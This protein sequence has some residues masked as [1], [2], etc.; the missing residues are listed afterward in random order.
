M[1]DESF[2]LGG[3]IL[4]K[5][6][7]RAKILAALPPAFLTAVLQDLKAAAV[8]LTF[9]LILTALSRPPARK[10]AGRILTVN[11]F[12]AFLWIVLPFST[13][14]ERLASFGPLSVTYEGLQLALLVTLKSNALFLLFLG[15]VATT[16]A[17]DLGRSLGML[18][19]PD[20]LCQLLIFSY[21]YV[22]VLAQ[23]Y[24]RL[25]VAIRVRGFKPGMNLHTYRTAAYLAAMLL[26]RGYDRA[27]RVRQAMVLRGFDGRF[28]SLAEYSLRAPDYYLLTASALALGLVAAV[29]WA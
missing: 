29:E 28:H 10:L 26:V 9:A 22:H 21:R 1:L 18:G 2:A 17:P 13:P 3:S 5:L 16:P 19:A 12:V 7:P 11:G 4:H 20:R 27:Q 24:Q 25:A 23:E 8:S 14:G 6:D 15:L